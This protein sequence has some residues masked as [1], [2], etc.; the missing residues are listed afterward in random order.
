MICQKDHFLNEE[1]VNSLIEYFYKDPVDL[2]DDSKMFGPKHL[3]EKHPVIMRLLKKVREC[4][5]QIKLIRGYFFYIKFP[6]KIHVDNSDFKKGYDPI[7]FLIPLQ[8]KP[9]NNKKENNCFFY[10]L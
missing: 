3:M 1:E 5:R 8:V 9:D 7:S 6:L 2:N 10:N 4:H